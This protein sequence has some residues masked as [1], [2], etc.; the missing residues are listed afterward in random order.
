[1][2]PLNVSRHTWAGMR[3]PS[4]TR[5]SIGYGVRLSQPLARVAGRRSSHAS[6]GTLGRAGGNLLLKIPGLQRRC[7]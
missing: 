4:R 7:S 3:T 2:S 6:A 1:M 5:S